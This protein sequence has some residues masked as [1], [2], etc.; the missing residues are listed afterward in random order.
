MPTRAQPIRSL[1]G[2]RWSCTGCGHCCRSF[3]LG[4][5]EPSTLAAL[6]AADLPARWTPA[7]QAP[8][9]EL[10]PGHD[11][12][13]VAWLSRRDGACVFLEPE[14]RCWLHAELGEASK[15]AFCREFPFHLVIER[16]HSSA[17][18][19]PTCADLHRSRLDGAPLGPQVQGL[20][21]LPR[22]YPVAR[23]APERVE[24]LPGLGIDLESWEA[25]EPAVLKVLD[26]PEEAPEAS[27]AQLRQALLRAVGRA[28]PSPREDAL[29]AAFSVYLAELASALLPLLRD[30]EEPQRLA[31]LRGAQSWVERAQALALPPPPLAPSARALLNEQLRSMVLGKL[32]HRLGGLPRA[33]GAFLLDQRMAR[34][35]AAAGPS[36]AIEARDISA[37]LVPWWNAC[38]HSALVR[39]RQ[40]V[41]PA[42]EAAFL[43]AS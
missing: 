16:H 6:E 36:G 18:V 3:D 25:V 30:D 32:F 22:A 41:A 8:W 23:F 24:I 11:G 9:Y 12:Q 20:A 31:L 5:V 35:V 4:P 19:R 40:R 27:V 39:A 28:L 34:C 38:A 33:L 29:E 10:R 37:V 42:L 13:P 2:A 15:P 43:N 17:V 7:A 26:A 14:G 1:P 21:A